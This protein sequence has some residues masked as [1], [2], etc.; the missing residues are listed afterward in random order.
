M[1]L[2]SSGVISRAQDEA[3][4]P[5]DAASALT[6][7]EESLAKAGDQFRAKKMEESA[8]ALD[9]AKAGYEKLTAGDVPADLRARGRAV[10]FAPRSRRAIDHQSAGLS[11]QAG[12][13]YGG[14]KGGR[15]FSRKEASGGAGC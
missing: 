7:I 12:R 5:A 4:A 10:G 9:E 8:A 14:A 2:S 1:A 3:A 15:E 13:D 6:A 11:G